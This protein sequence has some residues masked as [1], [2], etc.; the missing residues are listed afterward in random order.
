MDIELRIIL[1]SV[2]NGEKN[3]SYNDRLIS[4]SYINNIFNM[5]QVD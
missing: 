2:L 4:N 1:S 5:V 3:Y